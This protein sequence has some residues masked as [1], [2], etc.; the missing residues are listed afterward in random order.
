MALG[1]LGRVYAAAGRENDTRDF[2][3]ELTVRSQEDK[4]GQD[5][6]I[7]ALYVA[8]GDFDKAIEHV[9]KIVEERNSPFLLHFWPDF[10][11][12]WQDQRFIDLVNQAGVARYNPDTKRFDV[13]VQTDHPD[14]G[15]EYP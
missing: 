8:L 13:I 14:G 7:I 15:I 9:R 3:Q 4:I 1:V 6:H 5:A 11:P 2:L 10:R 12:L